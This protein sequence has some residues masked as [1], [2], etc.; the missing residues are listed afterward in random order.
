[1]KVR[2]EK[3]GQRIEMGSDHLDLKLTNID[4]RNTMN[5]V[6]SAIRQASAEVPAPATPAAVPAALPTPGLAVPTIPDPV[7]LPSRPSFYQRQ[8]R[9]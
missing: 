3:N 4:G 5:E 9:E 6:K 2:T 8:T 7:P 1:V